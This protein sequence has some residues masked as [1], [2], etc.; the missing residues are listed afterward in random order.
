MYNR[1]FG[2][3]ESPFG[4]APNPRFFYTNPVYLEAYANLCYGIEGKK[5]FIAL[6]GEV[7]TG[8]T[9]LLRKLMRNF[10]KT[11]DFVFI[12]NTNLTFKEL[13]RAI[14]HDLGLPT[15]GKDKLAMFEELNTYLIEQVKRGHIVCLLIDE[16][17]N[18][19]DESLEGL[20]L[21][22][23][24]ETDN[25]KLLQIV[26]MG[27]PEFKTK[28]NQPN[29]R[30]LKQRI[31]LQFEIAPLMN[32]EVGAYINFRL[33][34]AGYARQDLFHPEAIRKIAAY[35][36][37][38]PRLIN[39]ICDNALVTAFAGSQKTVSAALIREVAE[40]L[41]LESKPQPDKTTNTF[42]GSPSKTK[43]ETLIRERPNR[44]SQ[45][46]VRR[47]TITVVG[48]CL[49]ILVFAVVSV[50]TDSQSFF[51]ITERTLE[52][53]KDNSNKRVLPVH[54]NVTRQMISA[55]AD[56]A[57]REKTAIGF[58]TNQPIIVQYG[59]TIYE[60]ANNT[61]GTNAVLGMDLIKEFNPQI[62]DLNWVSAGHKLVLPALTQETLVRQHG[63]G[64]YRLI[65]SAFIKRTE[66]DELANRIRKE[67]YQVIVTTKRVSTD[68]LLH[69]LEID[70]LKSIGEATQ[71]LNTGIQKEWL[72]VAGNRKNTEPPVQP[73]PTY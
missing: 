32:E 20:R 61:Y 49:V 52:S 13:L 26:M 46:R 9:L 41:D 34:S 11:I 66:A 29:L 16:V 38:I 56:N 8:K 39:V 55:E 21:L 57:G 65:V 28:L 15:Q 19:S 5:G 72:N 63:D 62:K 14:L 73:I 33:Q 70:G 67:G 27:Q 2:F 6:T 51:G 31:A 24:F 17:Q 42:S 22:S 40:D 54:H 30:Q 59:S 18:L 43:S 58:K 36:K 64:S 48:A 35:S 12:F 71:S 7:G 23:N 10:A 68:L 3:L 4:I 50:V 53:F 60:I 1:Y 45:P 44:V 37:G 69:R 25:E 47:L